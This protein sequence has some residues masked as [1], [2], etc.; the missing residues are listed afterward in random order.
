MSVPTA[1]GKSRYLTTVTHKTSSEKL[2][3]LNNTIMTF[4]GVGDFATMEV[5][6]DLYHWRER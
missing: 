4:E 6:G 3:W 1:G 5:S 2:S